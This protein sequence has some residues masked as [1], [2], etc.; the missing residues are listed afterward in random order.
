MIVKEWQEW[1]KKWGLSEWPAFNLATGQL[2]VVA[3]DSLPQQ[4]GFGFPNCDHAPAW[5]FSACEACARKL[6]MQ[7]RAT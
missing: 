2:I 3:P 5:S 1:W 7:T 6:L 4:Y